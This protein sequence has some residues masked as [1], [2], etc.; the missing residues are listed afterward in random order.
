[1]TMLKKCS[2][3]HVFIYEHLHNSSNYQINL[4]LQHYSYMFALHWEHVLIP[5][6]I[7]IH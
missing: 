1:M 2:A 6:Y 7:V 4:H 5:E 3:Y